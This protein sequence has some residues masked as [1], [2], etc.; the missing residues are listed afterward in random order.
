MQRFDVSLMRNIQVRES[1][2]VQL[3]L[4]TFNLP[5]HTNFQGISTALGSSNYGQ[6]T[7]ARDP[8]RIQLGAKLTF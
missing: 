4:E 8:R 5:N 1:M 7:S 6:V 2:R 3:R